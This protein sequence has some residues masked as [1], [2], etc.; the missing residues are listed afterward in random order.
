MSSLQIRPA[1]TSA[2]DGLR[3]LQYVDSQL[4]WLATIGSATQWGSDPRSV[5]EDTRAKYRAKIAQSEAEWDRKYDEEW[6][7]AYIAEMVVDSNDLTS[8]Q[9]ALSTEAS[10]NK[11]HLAVAGMILAGRSMDYV[12]PILPRQ[13]DDDPFLYLSYL[14]SDRRVRPFGKGAGADLIAHAVDEARRL[15]LKRICTDC[16]RGNEHRLVKCGKPPYQRLHL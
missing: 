13:D 9:R 6:L 10:N 14:L 1:S 7:R 12:R 4:A 2:D 11:L 15:G 3:L 8:E 5:Q 16:W